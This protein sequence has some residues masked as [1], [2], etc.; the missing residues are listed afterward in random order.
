LLAGY[1]TQKST[2]EYSTA[3]SNDYANESLGHHNLAGGSIAISPT[4][5]GAESVL[6]SWL[7]R[8]NYS[9]FERYNFTAT[10]RADGSSRFAQNKRWGY[11]PSI[12]AAWNINEESFY[13]KSSVVN[14]LKLR[15]SAGTVGNQE[16]GDYR[17]EDYYSPS[18]YSFAGKTVI[19]YARSNRANPDLK[20]ENT[21][22]YNVRLDIGVWTKR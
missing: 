21:S 6:N 4:S 12:G 2:V 9:L 1:T 19:A 18:K 16:I 10:I 14:T 13:N 3:T 20:W 17:Y 11:F 8:V 22:Q 15:L 7:G 5:G